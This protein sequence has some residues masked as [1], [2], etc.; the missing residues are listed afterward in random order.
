MLKRLLSQSSVEQCWI[1]VAL[2]GPSNKT[3]SL[4]F[5]SPFKNLGYENCGEFFCSYHISLNRALVFYH[6]QHK[7]SRVNHNSRGHFPDGTEPLLP[8]TFVAYFDAIRRFLLNN[9]VLAI[10]TVFDRHYKGWFKRTLHSFQNMSK[11]CHKT[12]EGPFEVSLLVSN[13]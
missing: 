5:Q 4:Y 2:F 6:S 11:I 8:N 10:K 9:S 12:C 7:R 1:L 13:S 3:P